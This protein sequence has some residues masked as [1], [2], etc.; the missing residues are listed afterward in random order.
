MKSPST[1][2]VTTSGVTASEQGVSREHFDHTRKVRIRDAVV[3]NVVDDPLT[4]PLCDTSPENPTRDE[5]GGRDGGAEEERGPND[6][7]HTP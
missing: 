7:D 3:M 4:L 1:D 2:T 5:R 6:R